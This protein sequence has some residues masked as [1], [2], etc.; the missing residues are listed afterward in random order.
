MPWL[1]IKKAGNTSSQSA[2]SSSPGV[3]E[4]AV[5]TMYTVIACA[6]QMTCLRYCSIHSCSVHCSLLVC[7]YLYQISI[8]GTV[9]TETGWL[10]SLQSM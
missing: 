6:A 5:F 2:L 4:P 10:S 9:P 1:A 3:N 7:R 8:T